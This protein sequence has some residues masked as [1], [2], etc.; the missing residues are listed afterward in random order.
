[1]VDLGRVFGLPLGVSELSGAGC[2]MI[3]ILGAAGL[4]ASVGG[5]I[6]GGGAARRAAKKALRENRYR[7][8]AEKAWYEKE[9]NTDY[10]DTKAGQNLLRR[11]QEV[12]DGY[13]RKA[14]GAAAVGGGTAASVALA[15]ESANR[16]LGNAVANIGAQDTARKASVS[17]QHQRNVDALSREREAIYNQ[18]AQNVSAAA[19]GMSNAMMGAVPSLDGTDVGKGAA[20]V[21]VTSAAAKRAGGGS[22]V[23]KVNE[24]GVLYS[25]WSDKLKN[26]TGV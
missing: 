20:G 12:Q 14:D 1:M 26:V 13:I 18:Q 19:Q 6:I 22:L 5:S 25:K 17:D 21:D 10:L 24:A 7:T 8:N 4:A 3:G 2:R 9:Y 15:K 23:P 16:T 11:A